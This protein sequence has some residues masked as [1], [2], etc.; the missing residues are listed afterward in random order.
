[1]GTIQAAG[2]RLRIR[3]PA[4]AEDQ[5]MPALDVLRRE[6][7]AALSLLGGLKG[8]AV[9]LWYDGLGRLWIVEDEQ[10]AALAMARMKANR[11]EVWTPDEI[12]R[13]AVIRD[14]ATR[15]EVAQWKRQFAAKISADQAT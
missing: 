5:I 7:G 6:R 4:E 13:V 8:R 14:P 1:V 15:L 10:D 3:F 2:G 11:G 12:E 9:E